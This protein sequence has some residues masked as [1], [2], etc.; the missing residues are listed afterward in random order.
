MW[1]IALIDTSRWSFE[2]RVGVGAGVHDGGGRRERREVLSD[3]PAERLERRPRAALARGEEPPRLILR[4]RGHDDGTDEVVVRDA[5]E[6]V[7]RHGS[8]RSG[9]LRAAAAQSLHALR[10][11][12]IARCHSSSGYQSRSAI[13][14]ISVTVRSSSPRRSAISRSLRPRRSMRWNEFDSARTSSL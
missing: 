1:R 8:L 5:L 11:K 6:E 4:R 13:T 3:L 7:E 12:S 10:L 9:R 2:K 14:R